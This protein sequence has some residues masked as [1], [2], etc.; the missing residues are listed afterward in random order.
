[1]RK[2]FKRLTA[3]ALAAVLAVTGIPAQ[4]L[5]AETGQTESPEKLELKD[6][7]I[8][9]TVSGENGGF[10]I[11]TLEGNKL[12]KSDNNKFL[13]YPAEDYD[14]S[15]TSFSITRTD[16]TKEEY[17]FGRDY[18]FLGM[19]S[20]DVALS[21]QGNSLTAV[22]SV[23]DLTIRQTLSLLDE[24]AAQHGMVSVGYTV[25]TDRDDVADVK[26]RL[27]LDTA[28]GYQD[29]GVYE[30]PDAVGDYTHIRKETLLD[31][32]DGSAFA[33]SMFAVDDPGA[34]KVTAYTVNT[35]K[36]GEAIKPYQVGFGHWNHLASTV[37]DF[38]P[39]NTLDFTNPYNEAYETADSAYALY[40]DL[41][42]LEQ[43][44]SAEISTYYGV[45]SNATVSDE[46]KVAIN[47]LSLPASMTLNEAKNAYEPQ[48]EGGRPGD[49]SVKMAIENIAPEALDA[50]TV[51]VKTQ[52]Q[53]LPYE[54]WYQNVPYGEEESFTT[55]INDY[56][57]GETAQV[58]AF[59]QVSPLPSS[60]YR[61]FEVLC[62]DAAR[63][64]VL[65][66]AKLLGSRDFYLFCPGTL[67][68]KVAFTSIEPQ[69]VY[70]EGTKNVYLSGQNFA[71]LNDPTSY[72]TYLHSLSGGR[73]VIV[74]AKNVVVDAEKNTMYLVV[75]SSLDPGS[76]QV[77]F[78]WNEAGKEDTTSSMLQ[79][80][81]TDKPE[82]M[83]P[84]YGIVTIEKAPDYSDDA[85]RYRVMAYGDEEAYARDMTDPN[86][87]VLL[88]FRGN[89]SL[90]YDEA[91]NITEAKAVSLE[92]VE[93]KISNTI[94]I[95]NCLDV[96]AGSVSIL[97]QDPGTDG[98]V[99]ETNIDGK[100]YTTNS[101]TK[102]WDGVCAISSI[103]NGSVSTLL[104]Y[105]SDAD[106]TDDLENSVANT[107]A[108]TLIWPGAASGVQTLAGIM[109]EFRYCQ[110][111]M[112]ALEDGPVSDST[113]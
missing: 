26:M 39:D 94:N 86:N 67:G 61:R 18:G 34:P 97:V 14:T 13:L 93:G 15:Y 2:V 58:E 88:E 102:V 72:V 9:V 74:P 40:Y 23:K 32:Q 8:S 100:V 53:V 109:L 59:F 89:F 83:S 98:Q 30:L 45:F 3:A 24:S 57:P 1:M 90:W 71:M 62:Y 10:R 113:P 87:Q 99:I 22:W 4:A 60:E 85:P 51:V 96:E 31:N 7:Y 38:T 21:R 55:V 42:A 44:A 79:F 77:V 82:Y 80:L 105:T 101:R 68:E 12:K 84:V 29:Y 66:E 43:N 54:D 27:M 36:E 48:A 73:D 76:Y 104:Q 95:S 65:T 75:E 50:M 16:G 47:F 110:F 56:Q 112:M 107:N 46:E 69:M 111:G 81:A 25:T 17:I 52:N 70:T 103:E 49:V 35:L 33:G 28:L 92:D 5:A 106:Q 11:D 19:N 78:D 64:E 108:I 63:G 37:F 41:G 91:G 20:S 6:D